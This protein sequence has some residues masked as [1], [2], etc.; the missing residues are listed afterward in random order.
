[1]PSLIS[2][3]LAVAASLSAMLA[4]GADTFAA[5]T[6]S[7]A[8][9]LASELFGEKA[10]E[11]CEAAMASGRYD[12]VDICWEY[13]DTRAYISEIMRDLPVE[14]KE[15]D[16]LIVMMLRNPAN[17]WSDPDSFDMVG[18][19]ENLNAKRSAEAL[20][21]LLRKYLPDLPMRYSVMNTKEKRLALS[22]QFAKAAGIRISD[23]SDARRVWPPERPNK[24]DGNATSK[25]QPGS[26]NKPNGSNPV[27]TMPKT[28]EPSAFSDGWAWS[29][30]IV[31]VLAGIVGWIAVRSRSG[32][33]LRK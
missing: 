15:K 23:P 12:L 25:Q 8:R 28:G 30:G 20:I 29:A 17:L 10:H 18:G 14:S 26:I 19:D 16:A 3:L 27:A 6:E 7:E 22:V 21:P 33:K 11:F 9:K 4:W 1:M 13:P 2:C 5:L 24:P 32:K 31:A